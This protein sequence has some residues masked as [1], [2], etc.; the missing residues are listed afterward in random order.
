MSVMDYVLQAKMK[1]ATEDIVSGDKIID[2]ALKYGYQSHAGFTKAFKNKF[3]FSPILLRTMK[4]EI[5]YF[6]ER[7]M[8]NVGLK[9]VHEHATKEKLY[10]ILCE[11]IKHM[12]TN[13]TEIRLKNAYDFACEI[14]SG[15]NRYSGDEYVTHTINVAIML[16]QLEAS[17]EIIIAGL[18]CDSST[19]ANVSKEDIVDN[20]SD[21]VY[22]M[23][24]KAKDLIMAEELNSEENVVLLKLAE[25][26]HNMRTIQFMEEKKEL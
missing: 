3:G 11:N 20:T 26:L 7:D 1:R 19:K 5:E 13:I 22:K 17:E 8:G 25:R 23:L 24:V 14:Y 18:I 16:M 12:N 2:V 4:L 21:E 10:E 6:G 9:N 15:L